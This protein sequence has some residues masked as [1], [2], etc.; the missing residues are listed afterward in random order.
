M[1]FGRELV[2][3]L[4]KLSMFGEFLVHAWRFEQRTKELEALFKEIF[5]VGL[6]CISNKRLHR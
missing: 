4:T 3:L 6:V 1:P 5:G 2:V